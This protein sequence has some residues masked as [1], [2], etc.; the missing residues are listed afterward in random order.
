MIECSIIGLSWRVEWCDREGKGHWVVFTDESEVQP[1]MDAVAPLCMLMD[2]YRV[3]T[4][5]ERGKL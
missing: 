3:N 1:F 4:S 2:V 5:E